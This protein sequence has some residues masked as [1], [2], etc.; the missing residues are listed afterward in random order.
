MAVFGSRQ[1]VGKRVVSQDGTDV[2]EVQG[3]DVDVE[4]WRIVTVEIKIERDALEALGLKKPIFGTQSV[5][6]AC[7]QISGVSDSVVLKHKTKD[8]RFLGATRAQEI[9]ANKRR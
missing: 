4:F 5:R 3:F 8:V 9:E 1:L 6:L 2:G 7:D